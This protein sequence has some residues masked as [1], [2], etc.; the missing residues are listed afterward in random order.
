MKKK[1]V[2]AVIVGGLWED[3]C[4][5]WRLGVLSIEEVWSP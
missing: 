1:I 5:S 2:V 3:L 4:P